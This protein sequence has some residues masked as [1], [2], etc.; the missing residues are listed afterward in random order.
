MLNKRYQLENI[1]LTHLTPEQVD[2]ISTDSLAKIQQFVTAHSE[3]VPLVKG[4]SLLAEHLEKFQNSLRTSTKSQLSE[5]L[6]AADAARDSSLSILNQFVR[7]Y[8]QIDEADIQ[9]AYAKIAEQF[10][11]FKNIANK[12]YEEESAALVQLLKK[13]KSSDFKASVK[14]LGLDSHIARLAQAQETFETVYQARLNE[15]K[16]KVKSQS[17]ALKQTLTD[18]Y[19]SLVDYIAVNAYHHTDKSHLKDLLADINAIR[20]CYKKR[21]VVKKA[22][23][24]TEEKE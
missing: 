10:S 1:D 6:A 17:K 9:E 15:G 2:K 14:T 22:E 8:S 19:D 3:E 24:V 4:T 5:K 23:A 21:K 20:K 16:G 11:Q 13:L 7:T 18:S 12:S